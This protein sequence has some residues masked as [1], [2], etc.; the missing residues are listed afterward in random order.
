MLLNKV[1]HILLLLQFLCFY[2]KG[3][4]CLMMFLDVTAA[5]DP[6]HQSPYTLTH[7]S[8]V[9]FWVDFLPSYNAIR[10]R[11][12]QWRSKGLV[13][14]VP[15]PEWV[16]RGGPQVS[17]CHWVNIADS[18]SSRAPYSLP[19]FLMCIWIKL[20]SCSLTMKCFPAPTDRKMLHSAFWIFLSVWYP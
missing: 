6:I 15:W 1:L 10:T 11:L 20:V 5:F 19:H 8:K 3:D 17:L 7:T 18:L 13:S 16:R 14:T 9:R 2:E 4:S 12:I